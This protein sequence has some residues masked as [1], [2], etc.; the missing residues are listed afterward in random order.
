[1]TYYLAVDIGASS[2]RHIL[3]SLQNG[4]IELEEVYRFEN[5]M[6]DENGTLVWD[7]DALTNEVLAGIRQCAA[8]GKT[9]SFIGIDTWGVDYVLLDEHNDPLLPAVAY[10]DARN[11]IAMEQVEKILPFETLYARTGI[12]KQTFNTVYQLWA[13]KQSGK[14]SRAKRLL[15][16]PD[17]LTWRLTGVM[18]NEYTIASTSGLLDAEKKDWD[19]GLFDLLGYPHEIVGP[20]SFPGTAVGP[21]REAVAAQVGFSALVLHAP[22]HDTAAAVAACPIDDESVYISSGTWSLIGTENRRPVTNDAAR[23]A[24]FTNEGGVEGRYRFLDNIMGMWLFQRIRAELGKKYTYDELME[25]AK[26]GSYPGT[27]DCTSPALLAPESMLT[28][29]R[30]LLG[31]PALPLPDVLQSVYHSLASSYDRAVKQIESLSGKTVSRILIVGGG[32]K[33][34]YLNAYTA[35]VTGK[36]VVTGLSEAT[37]L[38]NLLTQIMYDKQIDLAAARQIVKDSFDIKETKA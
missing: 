36:T 11:A 37:A 4:K 23:R 38:G 17:Y 16:I 21:L 34:R 8:I 14:L 3:G 2:G 27:F 7:L 22:S 13:D 18:E 30:G 31:D 5:G 28:A 24:N 26:T 1:M 12:Q 9:P 33:D 6:R 35:R 20:L 32:S 25:M 10:R 29:I 15:F 19:F